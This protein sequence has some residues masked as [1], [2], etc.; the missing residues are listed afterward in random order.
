MR[1]EYRITRKLYQ[2]WLWE[3]MRKPPKIYFF[4]FWVTFGLL[5][6]AMCIA[7]QMKFLFIFAVFCIYRAFFRDLLFAKR[8]YSLLAKRYGGE[9]WTR[10]VSFEEKE[11]VTTE[12]GAAGTVS[13]RVPYGEIARI[14]EKD[15]RA[16]LIL[17]N[18]TVIRLYK[19]R[20]VDSSWDECRHFLESR[21][22][23]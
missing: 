10:T 12:N 19:D 15:N 16:W 7:M 9:N 22:N 5:I 6:T 14:E 18:K 17:R 2:T 8:Q 23:P 4:L 21:M 1:N 3:N 11:I 13:H 20:F